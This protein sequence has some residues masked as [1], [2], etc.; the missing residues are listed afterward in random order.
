MALHTSTSRRS[1]GRSWHLAVRLAGAP[2][3]PTAPVRQQYFDADLRG[4]WRSHIV[5]N[6]IGIRGVGIDAI[7]RDNHRGEFGIE[8]FSGTVIMFV[9]QFTKTTMLSFEDIRV[10]DDVRAC[11][12]RSRRRPASSDRARHLGAGPPRLSRPIA[13]APW[14]RTC[15]DGG[16]SAVNYTC[17]YMEFL[18][19]VDDGK[20]SYNG[21]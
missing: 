10:V 6:D 15:R 7:R 9:L 19:V 16:R 12:A 4:G 21:S 2:L 11:S 5:G 14:D 20:I 3:L 1:R 17:I 18:A 13:R 8:T